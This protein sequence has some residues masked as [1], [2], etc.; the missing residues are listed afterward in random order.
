MPHSAIQSLRIGTRT[1][2][3]AR[4]QTAIVAEALRQGA[5]HL[6]WHEIPMTTEGDRLL[7]Q[8]LPEIGGKGVFTELLERALRAGEIDLAVHSLKDLPIDEPAG[9]SVAA[10]C[11]RADPRDVLIARQQWT[12]MTLPH[13][14]RVGTSST[15]RAAQLRALR[16][17]LQLL[18]LR[19]NVDTRVEKVR[20]GQY[21]A[22]V[23]AAAG[24]HR[25]GLSDVITSYLTLDE[26]LPAPG[27]GAL[28]VQC[29]TDDPDI[30]ALVATLDQP[31]VR[32]ATTAERSFLAGLG[33]GC[34][35]PVAALAEVIPAEAGRLQLRGRVLA[36][37]GTRVV[38][39]RAEGAVASP[40]LLGAR[41]AN[42]ARAAGAEALLP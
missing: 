25:I 27:Q 3:L 2:R 16:P 36:T 30:L 23:L 26:M 8:P 6:G 7:D 40:H 14:A 13:G 4:R 5:P 21:D 20:A 22:I 15:R 10:I 28:A 32:A 39:V 18:D 9:V 35:A 34:A 1:S 24:L 29:R 11:C 31:D 42:E 17:D 33:G 38:E 41:L 12:L 37:D 19:G